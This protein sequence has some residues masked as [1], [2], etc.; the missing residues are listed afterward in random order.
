[1]TKV[2]N[3]IMKKLK[4]L[5]KEKDIEYFSTDSDKKASI[6]ERF[7][8]TLKTRMWKYLTAHETRQWD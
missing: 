5:F 7:N 3:S 2:N 8:R 1:M 4:N 6:V